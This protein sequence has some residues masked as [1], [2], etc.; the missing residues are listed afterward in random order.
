MNKTPP[1]SYVIDIRAEHTDNSPV[2][3]GFVKGISNT[4]IIKRYRDYKERYKI[5][6][7]NTPIEP[8][9]TALLKFV[10]IV[11]TSAI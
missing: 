3:K 11:N 1:D 9:T 10:R 2:A 7:T 4:E 8:N 6:K 5:T